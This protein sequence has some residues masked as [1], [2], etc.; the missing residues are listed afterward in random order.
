M[1][2]LLNIYICY[3]DRTHSADKMKK[4]IKTKTTKP[5]T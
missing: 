2:C 4:I 5:Y 1:P 3:K